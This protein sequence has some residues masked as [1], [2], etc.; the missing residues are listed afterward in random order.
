[1]HQGQEGPGLLSGGNI[2]GEEGC[3]PCTQEW[4]G[5]QVDSVCGGGALLLVPIPPVLIRVRAACP[6]PGA[7]PGGSLKTTTPPAACRLL[8]TPPQLTP[9]R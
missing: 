3:L 2:L 6:P 1:M 5:L 4:A 7:K 9:D 8:P